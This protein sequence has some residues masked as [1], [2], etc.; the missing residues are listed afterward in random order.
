MRFAAA[1]QCAIRAAAVAAAGAGAGGVGRLGGGRATP[2]PVRSA[3]GR[4]AL[5]S[6]DGEES[7]PEAAQL[8]LAAAKLVFAYNPAREHDC[9]G[10]PECAARAVAALEQL[11]A[12]ELTPEAYGAGLVQLTGWAVATE[13]Q[14]T[15]VHTPA[16]VRGL[17]ARAREPAYPA[18]CSKP[19][20]TAA[21][22][23]FPSRCALH[24][25]AA[26]CA[27][28]RR[29]SCRSAARAPM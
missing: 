14:L 1:Q 6:T 27:A 29:S 16:S 18:A 12:D 2:P 25:P 21:A 26:P 11:R 13:E 19:P 20:P 9:E 10:H 23:A 22:S 5:G 28:R 17:Q 8:S 4:A 7:P 3:R 15:R 24:P